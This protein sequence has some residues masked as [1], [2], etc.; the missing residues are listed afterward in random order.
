M[1]KG[2]TLVE[3]M[4][5]VIIMGVLAAVGVPKLFG[6]IAKA[7][8][9]EVPVAAGS[10]IS[11]QNAYLH[12]NNGVGSWKQIGYGAPGN[13]RS[14]YF[15]YSGCIN[16]TIT[17]DLMEP[18]MLGWQASNLS[19]LNSCRIGGIWA[20]VIDPAGERSIGYRQIISSMDCAALTVSWGEVGKGV[21][22]LCEATG[23][24]QVAGTE[25]KEPDPPESSAGEPEAT[26]STT[27]T[28][29]PSS[30]E[31]VQSSSSVDCET[32]AASKHS[33]DPRKINGNKCGWCYVQGC[34][35]AV[36][37]GHLPNGLECVR[38]CDYES[39]HDINEEIRQ[40]ENQQKS[41]SSIA[42]SA[43]GTS[44][45]GSS[46]SG[47]GGSGTSGSNASGGGGGTGGGSGGDG[48][49]EATTNQPTVPTAEVTIEPSTEGNQQEE[50]E[51]SFMIID[52]NNQPFDMS[53]LDEEITYCDSFNGNGSCKN[54]HSYTIDKSQ[55]TKYDTQKKMCIEIS[56]Q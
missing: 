14:N 39:E 32:L 55:C 24:M 56:Q 28:S 53:G 38:L 36:N 48:G 10:Y 30:S 7:R 35:L 42:S 54:K 13:G 20:V 15:E 26:S 50:E 19:S 2:F 16:G 3:I 51:N 34:R 6:V 44:A 52:Q 1:K 37:N 40:Y 29:S 22:G 46:A 43:S 12:E 41:S 21:E 25:N 49:G 18:N 45:G 47:S 31:S 9:S 4:V 5:V 23:E 27:E 8:A 11:V 17:F 33:S